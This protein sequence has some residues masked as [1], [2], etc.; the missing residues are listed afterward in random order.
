MTNYHTHFMENRM[1][2]DE[3]WTQRFDEDEEDP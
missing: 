2:V 1:V 3:T